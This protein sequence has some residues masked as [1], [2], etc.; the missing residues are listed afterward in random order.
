MERL[1]EREQTGRK[2]MLPVAV[3]ERGNVKR[4]IVNLES[5]LSRKL[6]LLAA[7][8]QESWAGLLNVTSGTENVLLFP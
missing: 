6:R 7:C 5:T 8:I 1:C 2:K 3:G 4:S